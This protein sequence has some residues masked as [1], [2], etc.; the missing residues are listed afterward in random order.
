MSF[1]SASRTAR[2]VTVD[3]SRES[4]PS[5]WTDMQHCLHPVHFLLRFITSLM[6]LAESNAA[7][8]HSCCQ[9]PHNPRHRACAWGTIPSS[10][11]DN[12]EGSKFHPLNSLVMPDGPA[13][14]SQPW[15]QSQQ[16]QL[17]QHY[18]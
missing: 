7:D 15:D 12:Q 13:S 8:R 5:L 1:A 17:E 18:R 4:W 9:Q 6:L 11:D 3:M 2:L 14:H 16:H 10:D